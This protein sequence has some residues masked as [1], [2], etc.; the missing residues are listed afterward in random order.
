MGSVRLDGGA[1]LGSGAHRPG[2]GGLLGDLGQPRAPLVLEGAM[3]R[4]R[5]VDPMSTPVS[6][7]CFGSAY[8]R[9]VIAVQAP[10]PDSNNPNGVGL[11]SAPPWETG[12]SPR[13]ACPPLSMR[14]P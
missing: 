14:T 4:D 1:D 12:S 10:S 8:I 5:P 11:L 13:R 7:H 2:D 3:Q 6:G 9:R